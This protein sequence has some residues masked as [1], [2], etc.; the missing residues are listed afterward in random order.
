MQSYDCVSWQPLASYSSTILVRRWKIRYQIALGTDRDV[1][2]DLL[3]WL[4]FHRQLW[5]TQRGSCDAYYFPQH[6]L[7][8][9]SL[10]QR[11]RTLEAGLK[12]SGG[13]QVQGEVGFLF[14][15]SKMDQHLTFPSLRRWSLDSNLSCWVPSRP[16]NHLCWNQFGPI[17]TLLDSL[18]G[19]DQ[20]CRRWR[21][22][23]VVLDDRRVV[24]FE[25]NLTRTKDISFSL[26]IFSAEALQNS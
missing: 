3:R 15:S 21:Q 9:K 5:G 20:I 1:H 6:N 7:S 24:V 13:D 8:V 16:F 4:R 10:Q 23:D 14:F 2:G 22:H 19:L 18:A 11:T 17:F 26:I 25:I 12:P